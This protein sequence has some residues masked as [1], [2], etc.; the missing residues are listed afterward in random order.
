M[1]EA[2]MSELG[3]QHRY[4]IHGDY[5]D[6]YRH[7]YEHRVFSNV[8]VLYFVFLIFF[9]I[10]LT[11]LFIVIGARFLLNTRDLN[12]GSQSQVKHCL[13]V[14]SMDKVRIFADGS[15]LLCMEEFYDSDMVVELHCDT[16][17]IYHYE[18]LEKYVNQEEGRNCPLCKA[19]FVFHV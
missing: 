19:Q 16:W 8:F 11:F 6:Y 9:Y 13:S 14:S 3:R 2:S 15:C 1:L 12:E 7:R 18:C 4:R 10:W 5:S 17:H